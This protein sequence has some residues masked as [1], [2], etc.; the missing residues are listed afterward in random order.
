MRLS[1]HLAKHKVG[2]T[3]LAV[4]IPKATVHDRKCTSVCARTIVVN[5][6]NGSNLEVGT[7]G[8]SWFGAG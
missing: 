5:M 7:I 6:L 2:I 3:T 4:V 1:V 8:V